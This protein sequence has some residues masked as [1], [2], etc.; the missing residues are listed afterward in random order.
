M[1]HPSFF[2][3]PLALAV[4][5]YEL[6]LCWLAGCLP[7]TEPC[8]LPLEMAD[9]LLSV[10]MDISQPYPVPKGRDQVGT[11]LQPKWFVTS[12]FTD[13]INA[14][15]N[16]TLKTMIPEKKK[17]KKKERTTLKASVPIRREEQLEQLDHLFFYVQNAPALN[18]PYGSR[19]CTGGRPWVLP[20]HFYTAKQP[21]QHI[22][23][24]CWPFLLS[25]PLEGSKSS[26][27]S[28]GYWCTQG[29]E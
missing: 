25:L 11:V 10:I 1:L 6:N 18:I 27:R 20:L 17:K 9:V 16:T 22:L 21:W 14:I 12:L 5:K 19:S 7:L 24:D 15:L 13:E 3:T 4:D 28:L 2:L 29:L 26:A 8:S 23:E